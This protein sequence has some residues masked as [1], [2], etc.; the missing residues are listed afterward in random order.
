[1]LTSLAFIFLAGLLMAAVCK[2]LKLPGMIGM[3]ITGIVLGPYVLDLLDPSILSVSSDLRQMA[4]IIILLK[5]GLSLD[6]SDLKKV[7]RPAIMMSCVPASCEILAFF[8]LAPSLL[9]VTRIEAAVM[10]AVLAA[11]SPAVVVP[12]MVRLM[13]E[14]YGTKKSIP[15]LILAGASCDDIF[16]IVLFSTFSGMAQGGHANVMGFVN[17]P[18]SIV[19]GIALGAAA[20]FVL[21]VFFE[22]SYAH[23]HCVRNSVKV[24]IVLGVSFLLMAVETWLKGIV[25]V[26]G[27]LAVVSMAC[28][29]RIRCVPQVTARLSEKFGKL[30]L[31]AEVILFVLVGA[32]VDIRYTLEAGIAAVAMI[33]TA[34]IFR[35]IGVSLCLVK[36][37]LSFKERLFCIIAYLPKATVQ[38]AI[39][40]VPLAMGLPCGK[41][42]LSVAVLAILITAPLG[43]I[44]IDSTYKKLLTHDE[45]SGA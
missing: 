13:D 19:L 25:S 36:T 18:V 41:I 16:V 3:L 44:G 24:I 21:S 1:M 34:L 5:A 27:L 23:R 33:F 38:A 30:W 39:G 10:G 35:G 2:R 12:R 31:A 45:N 32:A 28:V 11:V 42:V 37:S 29:I 8:L 14:K 22:T 17:I 4:L 9:G 40:S 6:L 43:A 26:S 15:Q 20:G 7:G